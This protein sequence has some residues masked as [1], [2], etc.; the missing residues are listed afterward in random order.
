[1][2]NLGIQLYSIHEIDDDTATVLDRVGKTALDGVEFFRLTDATAAAESL[3]RNGLDVAGAHVG[4]SALE[5]D[6]E[7]TVDA[8]SGLGVDRFVVPWAEPER[9]ESREAVETLASR[10]SAVADDLD[11]QGYELHYH[12][13]DQE[14]VE[15]GDGDD[16][17]L[18]ALAAAAPNVGLELDLGWAGAA[19]A[20]PLSLVETYADR[21]DLLHVKGYDAETGGPAKV[22]EGDLDLDGVRAAA[23]EHDVEWLVYESEGAPDTYDTVDHA[24][25]VMSSLR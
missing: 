10:L 17:A 3:D 2:P 7:E 25:D 20:D 22:G 23:D 12:N 4:L 16:Y 5:D 24:G 15:L 9:F 1:M 14:L 21:I 19:G 18:D 6:F 8:W 11:D 13:H